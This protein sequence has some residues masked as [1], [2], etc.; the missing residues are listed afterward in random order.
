[1][2]INIS[3]TFAPISLKNEV[4]IIQENVFSLPDDQSNI[5]NTEVKEAPLSYRDF[6]LFRQRC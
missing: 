6:T 3:V 2:V 1:M 4:S 5:Y